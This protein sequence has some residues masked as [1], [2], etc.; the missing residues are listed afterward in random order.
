MQGTALKQKAN[1]DI[2]KILVELLSGSVHPLP[3]FPYS[4]GQVYLIDAKNTEK[5]IKPHVAECLDD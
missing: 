4:F 5:S 3:I 2:K 1:I